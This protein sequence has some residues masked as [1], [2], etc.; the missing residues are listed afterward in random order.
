MK[1]EIKYRW[2]N[3]LTSGD[4]Q[5]GNRRLHTVQDGVHKFC[6]L[7]V[8]C[9]IAVQDGIVN[10]FFEGSQKCYSYRS[11]SGEN[12]PHI[13]VLPNSV[14]RWAGL[15]SANP[16][17]VLPPVYR[18]GN[19]NALLSHLND[20]LRLDFAKIGRIINDQL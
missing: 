7:G 20:V 4:Y 18:E 19:G 2:V 1:A 9:E 6:C 17:I 3:A 14:G 12:Y 13:G 10:R 16:Q 11:A 5:Q 8:L 15:Y